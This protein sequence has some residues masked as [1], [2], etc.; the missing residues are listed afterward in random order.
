M[1]LHHRISIMNHTA[2]CMLSFA[3]EDLLLGNFIGDYVK[4][5]TWEDYPQGVQRGILLHRTIDSFTD[6]H[7]AT[8]ETVNRI[9]PFAGRYAPPVVDILYD[10]LLCLQWDVF[11][12]CP[13]DEFAFWTYAHLDIRSAEFP[14]ALRKRWPHMLTGRFLHGYRN[15]AG[16]GWV[17]QQFNQR[18]DG[19]VEVGRLLP[20]FFEHLDLFLQDF[21]VFFPALAAQ[22]QTERAGW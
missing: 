11:G 10:H 16:L 4:G 19:R 9:R 15:S 7:P 3:D 21:N 13:F 18:L 8:R 22:V 20:F 14:A 2:H 5:K 1:R 17:L 12:P 6:N